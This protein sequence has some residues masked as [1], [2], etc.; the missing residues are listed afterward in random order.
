MKSVSGSVRGFSLTEMMTV[1]LIIG[2]TSAVSIPLGIN[3][4]RS[5]QVMAA[6]QAVASYFQLTRSQ[7]V[8]RN[9]RN[10]LIMNLNWPNP[11]SFQFTTIEANP[12][13]GTYDSVYFPGPG[14][15]AVYVPGNP[16]GVVPGNS[17]GSPG[18][19]DPSPHGSILT[20][21]TGYRFATQGG[22]F[23]SLLFRSN[24]TVAGVNSQGAT[25]GMV[26]LAANNLDFEI[27]INNPTNGLS[28]VI[29]I[30]TNGR[31]RVDT[32]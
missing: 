15:S 12:R 9:C 22:Q 20:L 6:S 16:Y 32:Q 18:N 1:V 28:R 30:T 3:Y 10:G 19:G 13:T 27:D 26:R 23:S 4:V 14:A 21:P 24:G 7:A 5:Y 25:P 11:S 8:K 2:I 31:V 17:T 29:R